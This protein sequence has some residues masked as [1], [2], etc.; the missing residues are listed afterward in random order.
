M[1]NIIIQSQK[2][3]QILKFNSK[4]SDPSFVEDYQIKVKLPI[5]H[6]RIDLNDHY[7]ILSQKLQS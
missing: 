5:A 7:H 1:F 3:T 2:S 6:L 4:Q